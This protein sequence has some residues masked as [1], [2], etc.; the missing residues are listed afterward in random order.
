MFSNVPYM[1]AFL[2]GC[3][4][5]ETPYLLLPIISLSTYT[6]TNFLNAASSLAGVALGGY[7]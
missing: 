6:S 1:G 5:C 3:V 7:C 2:T 4:L